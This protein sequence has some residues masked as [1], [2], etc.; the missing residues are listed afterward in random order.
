MAKLKNQM[1]MWKQKERQ[2]DRKERE[3]EKHST[4][5]ASQIYLAE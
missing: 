2:I 4:V 1:E 3:K 5:E